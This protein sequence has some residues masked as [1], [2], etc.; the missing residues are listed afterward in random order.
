[1]LD[2]K[3]NVVLELDGVKYYGHNTITTAGLLALR[4][5]LI[6]ASKSIDSSAVIWA[7][8][9]KL[10][11][12]DDGFPTEAAVGRPVVYRA[13]ESLTSALGF[14]NLFLRKGDVNILSVARTDL[15]DAADNPPPAVIPSG[16]RFVLSWSF[17]VNTGIDGNA[18]IPPEV[19]GTGRD[20]V[21]DVTGAQLVAISES[22]LANRIA[23]KENAS[24]LGR[25][26]LYHQEPDASRQATPEEV[27]V[28][29]SFAVPF[30]NDIGVQLSAVDGEARLLTDEW[31]FPEVPSSLSSIE[32]NIRGVLL[33]GTNLFVRVFLPVGPLTV[34][35][36][37]TPG[38][39]VD[40]ILSSA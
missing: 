5:A 32:R 29:P 7:D 6:D 14:S 25:I 28:D 9:A 17:S 38:R 11:D 26:R 39:T 34:R 13:S 1:M 2:K 40:V 20:R 4:D 27:L 16:T 24:N 35:T 37:T 22:R 3:N 19:S 30:G 36:S 23:G 18:E 33:F 12:L 15:K 10:S 21:V 8:A 31:T